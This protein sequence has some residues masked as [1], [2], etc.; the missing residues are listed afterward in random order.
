LSVVIVLFLIYFHSE[1]HN[2]INFCHLYVYLQKSNSRFS[3]Y[4]YIPRFSFPRSFE[5]I[6]I[7]VC[8]MFTAEAFTKATYCLRSITLYSLWNIPKEKSS[9]SQNI[10]QCRRQNIYYTVQNIATRTH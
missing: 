10:T 7:F 3:L 6:L 5:F 4:I 1:G 8:R 9:Y 2:S